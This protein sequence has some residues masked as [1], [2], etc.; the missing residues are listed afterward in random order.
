VGNYITIVTRRLWPAPNASTFVA[1]DDREGRPDMVHESML[2]VTARGESIGMIIHDE[3]DDTF[4]AEREK[5]FPKDSEFH[6][7]GIT[8]V[9]EDG[10]LL[11]TLTECSEEELVAADAIQ[12]RP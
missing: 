12:H 4:L 2:V 10:A 6:Y 7:E 9:C 8:E 11:Y 5:V 1:E 3:G